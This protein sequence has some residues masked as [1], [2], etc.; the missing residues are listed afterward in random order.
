MARYL[1]EEEI[2]ILKHEFDQYDADKGG[3]I[4][5]EEF[6]RVMKKSGQN[7]TDEE[8]A[9]IIK[10]VDLDG[11]GTINFD[12]F[13][14][15]MTGRTRAPPQKEEEC[16]PEADYKSAWKEFDPSLHG[17]I[18]ASQFRQMMAGLGEKVTDVEVDEII[19][20][21]DGEDKISYHEFSE[22]MKRKQV[23]DIVGGY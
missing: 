5:I 4:T 19:N 16:D 20:S 2:A 23:D 3:N 12:E 11:D 6:G 7:P 21:V 14:A 8:L 15:M 22:F 17:S 13:I 9:Q 1:S 10:E 18:S